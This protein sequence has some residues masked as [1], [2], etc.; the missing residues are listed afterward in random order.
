MKKKGRQLIS[1]LQFSLYFLIIFLGLAGLWD[2]LLWTIYGKM[3]SLLTTGGPWISVLY[4]VTSPWLRV[5]TGLRI[6]PRLEIP[7]TPTS[8]TAMI[9]LKGS[10][11]AP[12]VIP[13][14]C[15]LV[16]HSSLAIQVK[17]VSNRD[18]QGLLGCNQTLTSGI[19]HHL[20]KA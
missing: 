1:N 10:I 19:V 3:T 6:W 8:V 2:Q 11:M 20:G 16:L 9:V 4:C 18:Q 12:N 17:I 7:A 13:R 15:T 5:L 14:I